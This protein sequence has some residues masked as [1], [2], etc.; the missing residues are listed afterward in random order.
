MNVFFIG[1]YKHSMKKLILPVALACL[2]LNSCGNENK[3]IEV[4]TTVA[5]PA[6]NESTL[7]DKQ[8]KASF[9]METAEDSF[10]VPHTT[11]SVEYN[12]SRTV[13]DPMIC[14]PTLYDKVQMKDMDIPDNAITATGG[15]FAGGGDY[16]Y[17]VPTA[18]GIAVYKGWQDEQQ[19]DSGYHW[20][21]FKEIE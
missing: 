6:S 9:I 15:W 13:L 14:A 11:V 21:K 19:E 17:I 12:D 3:P 10:G 2:L 16:Y 7:T 8:N 1:D 5:A 18:K 4:D 20:E